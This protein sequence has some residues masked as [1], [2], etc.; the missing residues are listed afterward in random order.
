MGTYDEVGALGYA[1]AH[2][3]RESSCPEGSPTDLICCGRGFLEVAL[4]QDG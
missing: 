4:P 3:R 1:I 2:Q